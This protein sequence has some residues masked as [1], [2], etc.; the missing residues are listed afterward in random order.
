MP[1]IKTEIVINTSV[2]KVWKVLTDFENYQSWNPVVPKIECHP[3]IGSTAKIKLKANGISLPIIAKITDFTINKRFAWGGPDIWLMNKIG[4][5]EHYFEL[6]DLNGNQCLFVHGEEFRGALPRALWALISKLEA[7]YNEMN[8][9]LKC[10]SENNF[11][12]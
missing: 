6:H 5:A 9:A 12:Q 3:S 1:A 10:Q 2:E 7:S 11:N 8:E 4:N